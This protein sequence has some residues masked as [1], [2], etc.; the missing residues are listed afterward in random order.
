MGGRKLIGCPLA[1][2]VLGVGAEENEVGSTGDLFLE[3]EMEQDP[4][5]P[6]LPL[7]PHEDMQKIVVT[8]TKNI[9]FIRRHDK[10]IQNFALARQNQYDER[11][12]TSKFFKNNFYF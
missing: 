8:P 5:G 6:V 11:L 4:S 1:I 7:K 10:I 2:D 3:G 12:K 9:T